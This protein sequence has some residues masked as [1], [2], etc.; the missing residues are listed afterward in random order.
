M[1]RLLN[2]KLLCIGL[3]LW[4]SV[5]VLPKTSHAQ[6][7][8]ID[9]LKANYLEGFIG[10][11]RWENNATQDAAT[12]GVIGSQELV[13][14]LQ[15]IAARKQQGRRLAIRQLEPTDPL[16]E[17]HLLFV[18]TG[19]KRHWPQIV[20]ATQQKGTLLVGE[21]SG[22]LEAGGSIQ[23]VIRRNNLRFRISTE[24]AASSGVTVS[25]KL[26]ELAVD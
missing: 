21:E 10:F 17:I 23:F 6:V 13:A 24:N 9:A 1:E 8:Q 18:G 5:A 25:S 22:F 2:N 19:M 11:V 20:A 26:V 15:K 4:A 3:L 12:I 14:H 7:L 16:D